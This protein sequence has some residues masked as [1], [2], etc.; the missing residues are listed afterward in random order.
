[1]L[2]IAELYSIET[3]SIMQVRFITSYSISVCVMAVNVTI[4]LKKAANRSVKRNGLML[5]GILFVLSLLSGLLGASIAQYTANQQF[6]PLEVQTNAVFALPPLIAGVLSLLIGLAS[7]VVGIAAIRVFVTDETEQVPREYFTRNMGWA[8]LNFIVGAIVFGIAV[9]LGF[10]A[11]IIPGIFLL[12]TLAFW[13]IFVA[14]EDQNFIEGF[15]QSWGLTRGHRLKLLLLG[16]V[17]LLISVVI[18][19]I[20][21]VGF[22]GG[23]L[24][25]LVLAQVGSAIVTV[26]STAALAATYTELTALSAE[27]GR[28]S[29]EEE[30][31]PPTG[32]AE[33]L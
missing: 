31:A 10:V 22:V 11:L 14:V 27:E 19:A 2:I 12:V 17:V 23:A 6:V 33:S 28:V 21:G 15:R 13:T 18:N 25:G 16:I 24:V 9:A 29:V 8:V 30:P 20:F 32:G 7:L 5:M 1:M 4:I 3:D 26:F